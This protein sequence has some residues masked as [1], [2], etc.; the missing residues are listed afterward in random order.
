MQINMTCPLCTIKPFVRKALTERCK[1]C[2]FCLTIAAMLYFHRGTRTTGTRAPS[3]RGARPQKRS[4][5][6]TEIPSGRIGFSIHR[7]V[8]RII[9]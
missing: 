4:K 6:A 2:Y 5:P 1:A 7:E 3:P 8:R 9:S